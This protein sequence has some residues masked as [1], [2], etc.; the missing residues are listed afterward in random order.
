M[1]NS[2]MVLGERQ[3][4]YHNAEMEL[5]VLVLNR[6][7]SPVL[8][9]QLSDQLAAAIDR[10]ELLAGDRLPSERD[11]AATLGI[12]RTTA[13]NAYRELEARGLIRGFVG[14][15][16]FV[17]A[18][19]DTEPSGAP[20]AWRGKLALG[21]QR[22]LDP[23]LRRIVRAASDPSV[24]SFA[25]GT[26]A[27]ECFP[28]EAFRDISDRVLRRGARIA[29]GLGPTEGQPLLRRALANRSGVRPDQLLIL[30]GSQQGL[31]LV[32]R[33]LLDPGDAVIIDR[34]GYLG[35]IQTFRAAGALLV[36]WDA[37]RGDLDELEDL[38]LRYRPKLLYTTTTFQNPTGQTWPLALRQDVLALTNRYR[39]PI[40]EDDPY[41]ELWFRAAPPPSLYALDGGRSVIHIETFS[42]TL[43]GGLR[44]AWL[45]ANEAIVEQLALVK[46]RD[47][48]STASLSQFVVAELLTSNHFDRHLTA[49]RAEHVR[50]HQTMLDAIARHLPTG[51]LTF[52][53][54]SG[55]LYLWCH[56]RSGHRVSDLLLAAAHANVAFV[57]GEHFYVD[58]AG[59]NELRLCFSSV[60]PSL[61]D[62]GIRRLGSLVANLNAAPAAMDVANL[63]DRV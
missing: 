56:L 13:V 41:R 31:D 7:V 14:R 47:D 27:L 16:T 12:S 9:R 4:S 11:L 5:P 43:A 23:T 18:A 59:A 52:Q 51:Q 34:P 50:R 44:L 33:C 1:T 45:T 36:G 32:S 60:V 57:A 30:S 25:A 8:Y 37:G 49:L 55:G 46:L 63:L 35:A 38:I 20:F 21:A 29:L 17:C 62:E 28:T 53:P 40:V 58:N 61:I 2:R 26:P 6:T 10:G 19:P 3:V 22:T 39:L 42:K 54:A 48:V 15:G 24:I